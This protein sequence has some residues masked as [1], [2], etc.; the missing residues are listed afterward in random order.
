[1]KKLENEEKIYTL[2]NTIAKKDKENFLFKDNEERNLSIKVGNR[3]YRVKI[4]KEKVNN[5]INY[6]F[7]FQN[8]DEVIELKRQSFINSFEKEYLINYLIK[9]NYSSNERRLRFDTKNNEEVSILDKNQMRDNLVEKVIDLKTGKVK[10]AV[11]NSTTY[12]EINERIILPLASE[13]FFYNEK[14]NR[15]YLLA[16]EDV[17]VDVLIERLNLMKKDIVKEI[18]KLKELNINGVDELR[19]VIEKI[20][21]RKNY[22][23]LIKKQLLFSKEELFK[24]PEK[25]DFFNNSELEE[26]I[27]KL[28]EV[29]EDLLNTKKIYMNNLLKQFVK[30]GYN[31][32]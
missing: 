14:D 22:L 25:L 7:Y 9:S 21:S 11:Y 29:I 6:A 23:N 27:D 26:L 30:K 12:L 17:P 4:F 13:T 3:K 5:E 28:E 32:I 8:N 19:L 31:N 10:K 1:M 24:F 2:L 16:K 20:D 18:N 15:C